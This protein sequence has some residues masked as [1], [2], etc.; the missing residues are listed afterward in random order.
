MLER[1]KVI[2]IISPKGGAGKT[3]T[4]ANLAVALSNLGK[5]VLAIDANISTASLGFHFG[6][7]GER[8]TFKEVLDE[9]YLVSNAVIKYKPNLHII[10][11]DISMEFGNKQST[12][13]G[14]IRHL[15]NYY[16]IILSQ[17]VRD[18]DVILLDSAPGFNQESIAAMRASDIMIM[19]INPEVP[20]VVASTKG[21]EYS[22]RLKKKILG[23][24]LNK[25]LFTDYE[26][27]SKEIKEALNTRILAEV[28][29]DENVLKAISS[30][31]PVVDYN[32][33]SE[34]AIAYKKLAAHL[35]DEQYQKPGK[36]KLAV[37][38]LKDDYESF[39]NHDF[40]KGFIYYK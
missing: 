13:N 39:K 7:N 27:T 1:S 34:A 37:G 26:L 4:T 8:V 12:I 40:S 33:D 9:H 15:T 22:H 21:I 32:A 17:L 10:T 30:N 6:I 2:A 31:K 11:N 25:M 35:A 29:Y 19:V 16:D 23:V 3:T 18:Y 14:S 20:S 5:K 28:P 36:L 38:R 24:V